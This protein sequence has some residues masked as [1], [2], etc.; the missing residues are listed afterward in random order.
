VDEEGGGENEVV[1]PVNVVTNAIANPAANT[2]GNAA[3][4]TASAVG[5]QQ[6]NAAG[7]A[8]QN[9]GAQPPPAQATHTQ[10]NQRQPIRDEVEIARHANYDRDNGVPNLLDTNHPIQA[11]DLR[12]M[13]DRE[14]LHRA[15]YDQDNGPPGDLYI[16]P[17]AYAP[18]SS[19]GAI[20]NFPVFS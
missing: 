5:A 2:A 16:I 15:Q 11:T 3:N 12:E 4:N 17:T 7:N 10:S 19:H 9:V 8:R 1:Q 14:L 18:I 13:H 20:N 6:Q